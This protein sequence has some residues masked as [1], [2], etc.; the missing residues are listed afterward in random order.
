ME[1]YCKEIGYQHHQHTT[2]GSEEWV[3][4]SFQVFSDSR[5]ITEGGDMPIM[6]ECLIWQ[7][8]VCIYFHLISVPRV[9]LSPLVWYHRI[10][11]CKM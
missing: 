8:R 5:V 9:F 2:K 4:S 6:V 11:S 1:R 7:R 3:T 10:L